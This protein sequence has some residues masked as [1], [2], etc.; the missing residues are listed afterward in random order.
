MPAAAG[1][2]P[3]WGTASGAVE[4]GAVDTSART[5][6]TGL[7]TPEFAEVR[8]LFDSFLSDDAGYSA[9]LSVYRRGTK[10]VDLYGGPGFAP[11]DIT[12]T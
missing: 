10:V 7:A 8:E 12:G 6:S 9:Q 1:A 3:G 5:V 2:E 4:T 11:G